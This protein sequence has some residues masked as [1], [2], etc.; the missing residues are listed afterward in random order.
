MN[1]ERTIIVFHHV[2]QRPLVGQDKDHHDSLPAQKVSVRRVIGQTEG[3]RAVRHHHGARAA[4]SL[5]VSPPP[6]GGPFD[7]VV[8]PQLDSHSF[9]PH[10]YDTTGRIS[11]PDCTR[12][13]ERTDRAETEQRQSTT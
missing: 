5:N 6:P 9:P 12:A 4:V 3:T 10:S 2:H 7:P 13:R 1:F 11:H 8:H